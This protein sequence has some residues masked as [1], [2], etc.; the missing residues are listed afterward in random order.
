MTPGGRW[1]RFGAGILAATALAGCAHLPATPPSHPLAGVEV[2]GSCVPAGWWIEPATRERLSSRRVVERSLRSR[3]VLLG[4]RHDAADDHRWQLHT[5]AALHALRP[6]L[7]VGFEAFPRGVQPVLDRWTAGAL[8]E[9][10]LLAETDW[11]RVWG[12]D[13]ALYLPLF[14]FARL[15]RLPMLALNVDRALVAKVGEL[16]FDAVAAEERERIGAPAPASP[17]YRRLLRDVFDSHRPDGRPARDQ[18]AEARFI[19]AQLTW[20][21]AMAEALATAAR[22]RPSAL[23]VGLIGSGHLE[24]RFG[25]PRQLAALGIREVTVLLPWDTDRDCRDLTPDVADAVFG[26]GPRADA[27]LG[28]ALRLGV[29]LAVDG[30]DQLRVTEIEPDG[31]AARA[32]VRAGDIL[33]EAAG[34]PLRT[35]G[36]LRRIVRRQAPGTWLPL[37]VRRGGHE[38]IRIA[39]FPPEPGP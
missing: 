7:V 20:D 16:G 11:E 28:R 9:R 33:V 12:H 30:A 31:L 18:V 15:G 24:R 29:T 19:E 14:H 25:V 5:V 36:D 35:P 6:D 3:I 2:G 37:R 21:R 27:T 32:G 22:E 4:E 38:R 10:T 23:V 39:R 34:L 1:W 17:E 26:I 13:P 8:D